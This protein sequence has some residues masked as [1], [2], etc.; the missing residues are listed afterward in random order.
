MR[1]TLPRA[2][3]IVMTPLLL[4][5]CHS[6]PGGYVRDSAEASAR[7]A[8]QE[9]PPP[10]DKATYLALIARMQGQGAWFASLAHIEAFK[11]Q[12]GTTTELRVMNARA[13]QNTGQADAAQAMYEELTT[14]TQAA[15]AWHGLGLIHAARGQYSQAQKALTKASQLSPLNSTYLGDLG[16]AYLRTGQVEDARAPLA[17]AAELSPG[18]PRAVANLALWSLLALNPIQA[19]NIMQQ[20]NLPPETREQIRHLAQEMPRAQTQASSQAQPS[21]RTARTS[22]PDARPEVGNGASAS[23]SASA[24][25]LLPRTM[26]QRFSEQADSPPSPRTAQ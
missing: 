11:K 1:P 26:L 20:A 15:A 4:A 6:A 24:A 17:Q 14:G 8:Q 22:I 9:T 23:A 25:S 10:D 2:L 13:L 18:D 16:F 5:A 12:Y 7:M 3:L 19:E 21:A